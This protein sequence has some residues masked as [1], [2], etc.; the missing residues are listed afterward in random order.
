MCFSFTDG[1]T[2]P[3]NTGPGFVRRVNG[4]GTGLTDLVTGIQRPRGIALDPINGHI[5]WN[6][7]DAFEIA[8]ADLD[9][10]N[11]TQVFFRL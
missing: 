7:W 5:Y 8:R 3:I 10:S 4:D 11:V 1:G 6:D 2:G 9:G